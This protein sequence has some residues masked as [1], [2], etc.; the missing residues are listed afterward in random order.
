[1]RVAKVERFG[2]PEVLMAA[3]MPDPVAG[4]GQVVVRVTAADVLFVETVVRRGEG[5]GYFRSN[6][7]TCPVERWPGK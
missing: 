1:M 4:P 3:E 7:P 5:G 6:R 2:G